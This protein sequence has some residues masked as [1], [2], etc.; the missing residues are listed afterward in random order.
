M[1]PRL[2]VYLTLSVASLTECNGSTE[3]QLSSC[4][5]GVFRAEDNTTFNHFLVNKASGTEYVYIGAVDT[6]FQLH[7][8]LTHVRN[9]ST[10]E[11]PYWSIAAVLPQLQIHVL[12]QTITKS[13]FMLTLRSDRSFY[14]LLCAQNYIQ[15]LKNMYSK[16]E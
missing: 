14:P 10:D 3:G 12:S 16:L 1:T 9:D 8:D 7:S 15:I 13:S 6:I 2:L 5:K 11:I 4:M